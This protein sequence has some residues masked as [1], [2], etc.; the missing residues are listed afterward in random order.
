MQVQKFGLKDWEERGKRWEELEY[1]DG[2]EVVVKRDEL[3]YPDG[4]IVTTI[5][6]KVYVKE[7]EDDDEEFEAFIARMQGEWTSYIENTYRLAWT[8]F[9]DWVR[10]RGIWFR[11]E[12]GKYGVNFK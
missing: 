7:E 6:Y 8:G 10:P 2:V 3:K 9:V 5:T 4:Q 1:V 11:G 12:V